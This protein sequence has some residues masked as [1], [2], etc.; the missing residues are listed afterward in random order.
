MRDTTLRSSRP[1]AALAAVLALLLGLF[2]TQ[3]A[4]P[5]HAAPATT[6]IT[7]DG[8]GTGR[9]FDGIGAISGG[10]G[11]SRLLIDYPEPERSQ[12]LDYL[13]KPG[14][15]AS[16][17]ILKVEIGGDTNSTDGAE[18]SYQHAKG[19]VDCNTGYEWW[20]MGQ[21]KAR[22]PHIK[23]YGLAWGA[24]GWVSD[25]TG[26]N[27][28][29][30]DAVNYL[31]GWL[32]CARSHGLTID[33]LG[34]WNERGYNKSWYENLHATL[35]A[36]GYHHTQVVGA[37][38]GWDVATAMRSD[39]AF[40]NSVDIIGTHYPCSYMSAMTSCSTT[41]DALATGKQLWASENGSED[42]DTGG[43]PMARAIN[44]GYLDAKMSA[45]INWPLIAAIYPNLPYNTMGLMTA[46][47]PWSGTY[48]VGKSLWAAAQTTQFTD[49][50]WSYIDTASGY[51]GG[52]RTNG[53]YV[54]YQAP[55]STAWSTVL[56][57]LDATAPQTVTFKV[58]GGLP[59]GALHVWSSD[60]ASNDQSD[61]MVRQPDLTASGGTY[62]L[63]VQPGRVYTV[64]TV[65]GG[66]AGTAKPPARGVLKLPY[67]DSFDSVPIGGEAPLL[68][69]QQGSFEAVRCGGGRPG[70]CIQ[71]MA[72]SSPV[73]W[74]N[75]SD[76]YATLGDLGWANYT[77]SV[78]TRL[79]Q[80]GA[81]QLLGRVGTQQGFSPA[82][83]DAYYLTLSHD[84]SWAIQRNTTSHTVTT[85][86]SGTLPAAAGDG[87]HRLSLTF[88][89]TAITASVD[90]TQVGSVT[91]GSYASGQ[92]GIGTSGY[93][94]A[95]FDNL[96][97]TPGPEQSY[98]GTY[99]LVNRNSGKVLDVANQLAADGSAVDQ[100]SDNGGANQQW[101]V[102]PTGDGYYRLVG[103]QSG[104]A[105]EVPQA[106]P[107][108]GT[109]LD[110]RA[111]SAGDVA[112]EWRVVPSGG[113][114]ATV[115]N[116]ATGMLADVNGQSTADGAKVI[117]WPANGGANQQWELVPVG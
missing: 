95:Q 96:S 17:Q 27:F 92:V 87:W 39:P 107:N 45:Y 115:E 89:S 72:P 73:T 20:L 67:A 47:Q 30:S 25:G 108:E 103:V 101:T 13:F 35:A 82:G 6:A 86:A 81:V 28:F 37:D 11:N 69:D 70:T 21:A 79:T 50:G 29:T 1:P 18:S 85:L 99:R 52:D 94:Q 91:D 8:K 7:V 56:E 33:Y 9:T 12:I 23:L 44:R 74:D 109:Q 97:I 113:G 61:Y 41:S 60:F 2:W 40:D 10:G 93:V 106:D 83:I 5:A 65:R 36:D 98:A 42:Y 59:G 31:M 15:G 80:D 51:L 53:S 46:T 14:Y 48:S 75:T 22:N 110:I 105:L 68:A 112:Q 71:Q 77:V 24:P 114:Y 63:T 43:A 111:A 3:Q 88:D 66:G 49:P 16:L 64:T 102:Q 32:G 117:E 57:T 55:H 62:S 38:S 26:D 34:G 76:P 104:K 100:W 78:D 84:G 4:A 116:R 58:T 54:S 90:G 19:T